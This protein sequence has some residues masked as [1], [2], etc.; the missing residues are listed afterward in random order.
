MIAK[1]RMGRP[2]LPKGEKK[3]THVSVR[4]TVEEHRKIERAAKV[5]GVAVSEWTRMVLLTAAG[6]L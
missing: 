3:K 2:P 5:A 4:V 1:K 6:S